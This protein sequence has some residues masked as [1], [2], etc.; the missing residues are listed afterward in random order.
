MLLE[1]IAYQDDQSE[2][3]AKSKMI[4]INSYNIYSLFIIYVKLNTWKIGTLLI[5]RGYFV[6]LCIGFMRKEL[7]GIP[8]VRGSCWQ[9]W[10]TLTNSGIVSV[11]LWRYT[12]AD[13][14]QLQ[15]LM[16]ADILGI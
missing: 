5:I 8:F 3:V 13:I 1:D 7:K 11:N 2:Y 6:I 4:R 16:Y 10:A 12:A 14:W 15:N 9:I